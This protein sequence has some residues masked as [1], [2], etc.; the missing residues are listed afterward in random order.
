MSNYY[1]TVQTM[2]EFSPPELSSGLVYKL[3]KKNSVSSLL[4]TWFLFQNS[5]V[6]KQNE[7]KRF[8]I[9]FVFKKPMC[10]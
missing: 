8:K 5:Y 2:F 1:I 3:G 7:A 9:K 10:T 6:Q 4:V